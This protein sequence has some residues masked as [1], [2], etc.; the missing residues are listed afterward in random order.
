MAAN[1]DVG[2]ILNEHYRKGKICAAIC[3]GPRALLAH[4]IGVDHHHTITCYPTV[5]SDFSDGQPYKLDA[6]ENLVCHSSFTDK[7]ER[8]T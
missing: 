8:K 5:R 6:L 3:A 7:S 4:K 1:Q 2:E